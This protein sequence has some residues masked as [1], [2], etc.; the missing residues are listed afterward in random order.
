[1]HQAA[2]TGIMPEQMTFTGDNFDILT[3]LTALPVAWLAASGWA[4]RWLVVGWNLMG[5]VLLVVIVGIAGASMPGI[6]AFGP[7][8]LN[9]WIADPP[10]I[11]LPGVLVQGAL[12]GHLVVWRKLLSRAG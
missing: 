12:L 6:A 7:E 2:V 11:W 8:R 10:Y 9:T 4:P 5:S 3:G 1:M